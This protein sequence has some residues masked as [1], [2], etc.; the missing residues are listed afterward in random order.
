MKVEELVE[1]SLE[2]TDGRLKLLWSILWPMLTLQRVAWYRYPAKQPREDLPILWD[3]MNLV[4]DIH[5]AIHEGDRVT[6]QRVETLI[7]RH[8]EMMGKKSQLSMSRNPPFRPTEY[9]ANLDQ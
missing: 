4:N 8:H 9:P 2:S 1:L 6:R 3:L 7:Q 5:S